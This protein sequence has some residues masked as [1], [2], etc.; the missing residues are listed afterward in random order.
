MSKR[1]ITI[2]V[3]VI[4]VLLTLCKYLIFAR[5]QQTSGESTILHN[6]AL[7]VELYANEKNDGNPPTSWHQ[8]AE[9]SELDEMNRKCLPENQ[10]PIQATY[11]IITN[12][13]LLPPQKWKGN[14]V[15]IRRKPITNKEGRTGRFYISWAGR[16]AESYWISEKEVQTMLKNTGITLPEIDKEEAQRAEKV[17]RKQR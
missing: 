9:Y 17:F 14:V 5:R 2:L 7:A 1:R 6:V 4:A 15:L 16:Y 10:S 3:L 8:I 12:R 11:V 13:S